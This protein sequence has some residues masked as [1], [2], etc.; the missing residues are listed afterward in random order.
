MSAARREQLM[1][2]AAQQFDKMSSPFEADW[3]AQHGVSLNECGDL[4][5]DVARAIRIYL[6][7]PKAE[8]TALALQDAMKESGMPDDLAAS[9]ANRYRMTDLTRRLKVL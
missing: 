2:E 9:A 8:R 3:L 1:L 7:L 4:S 6:R 5:E